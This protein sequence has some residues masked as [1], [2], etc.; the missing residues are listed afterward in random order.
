[1]KKPLLFTS[2]L[3]LLSLLTFGQTPG[4]Q[5]Q[6]QLE[7]YS[8]N[9]G[10]QL[11][12]AI[13][14]V[15]NGGF[16]FVGADS[17]YYMLDKYKSLDKEKGEW[18]VIIRTDTAGK[19]IWSKRSRTYENNSSFNSVTPTDSNEFIAAGYS[20]RYQRF[21]PYN[22]ITSAYVVKYSS[23]G[24]LVWEKNLGGSNSEYLQ[25][26][27]QTKDQKYVIAG[28]TNSNDIDVSGNHGTN[29]YDFWILKLDN[30]GKLLWQ[31]CFGGSGDEKAYSIQ[32]TSDGGFIVAGKD[33]SSDGNVTISQG[34]FDG[35]VI[36]LDSS[37][38]LQWQKSV[39]GSKNDCFRSVLQ[40][41]D[42]GYFLTGYTYSND[43]D[44]SGNH[45]NADVWVVRLDALGN[46]LWQ[47]CF[48]GSNEE[49]GLSLERTVDGAYLVVGHAQSND[50]NV[51]DLNGGADAWLLKIDGLGNL[52]WQKTAGSNKNEFGIAVKALSENEFVIAGFKEPPVSSN[53]DPADAFL[54]KLGN[55]S[56]IKGT[57]FI[58]YNGDG[59]KGANDVF[60]SNVTIKSEKAGFVQY[61]IPYNGA[62][63]LDVDTGTY[64]TTVLLNNPYYTFSPA[65]H[66]TTFNSYFNTDSF[67]FA[68]IPMADKRDLS[69][70]LISL[71][72]ARPGFPTRYQLF[73]KNRGTTSISSSNSAII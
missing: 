3:V 5:W 57:V 61:A 7:P 51:T 6:K 69:V 54:F 56:S 58:D 60:T 23:E 59:I 64:R 17:T 1:M 8:Y 72:A 48:G 15:K 2:Y 39:G 25:S 20:G 70:N 40:T 28:Y 9:S 71:S 43:L 44:V 47:K 29:T 45:G 65:V 38:N 14:Q 13:S 35:W 52:K 73:Y 37:G 4:V 63:K 42:G 68:I 32:Q 66:N 36:K 34:G 33:S 10:G 67:S 30:T 31:K 55:S 19:V 24:N 18:P 12:Y 11:L 53:W 46:I 49:Y 41:S 27:I 62:F 21:S 16:I 26:L 50:G 22:I